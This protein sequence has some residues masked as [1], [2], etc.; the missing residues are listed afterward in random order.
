M[1]TGRVSY[2]SAFHR[3]SKFEHLF[4]F[5]FEQ[6]PDARPFKFIVNDMMKPGARTGGRTISQGVVTIVLIGVSRGHSYPYFDRHSVDIVD[7]AVGG[8]E[9][10]SWEEEVLFTL[11]HEARH[12]YQFVHG[13]FE[14]DDIG[15]EIDAERFAKRGLK[16]WRREQRW[17][18]KM[19]A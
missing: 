3:A 8:T 10:E 4:E 1:S 16:A 11:L 6:V 19:A 9:V 14:D 12:V 2:E 5:L 13:M 15:A 7:A 18:S 17:T